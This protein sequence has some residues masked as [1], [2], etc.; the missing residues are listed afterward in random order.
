MLD[1]LEKALALRA[2][3]LFSTLPA[4]TLLP[5]ANLCSEVELDTGQTLFDEGDLGDSL[6]VIVRGSIRVERDGR[7]LATLM[8]GE[9]VGEMAAIDWE[10]RSAS[11]VADE[12]SRLVRLDRNDLMDLLA[13]HPELVNSLAGVL[14]GRLRKMQP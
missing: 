1:I 3:P 13:D 4:D 5:V 14:V 8:E 7:I 12:P 9:C 6:Y 10:P 11:V 2:A